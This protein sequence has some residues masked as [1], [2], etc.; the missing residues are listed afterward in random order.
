MLTISAIALAR[1]ELNSHFARNL[2]VAVRRGLRRLRRA[3]ARIAEARR[4]RA[5][6]DFLLHADERILADIGLTRADVHFAFTGGKSAL[7][8]AG[9]RREQARAV[10]PDETKSLPVVVSPTLSPSLRDDFVT[11][12]NFR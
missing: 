3:V 4:H 12:E 6:L 8:D 11:H 5:E 1:A 7:W 2:R 10:P 9:E